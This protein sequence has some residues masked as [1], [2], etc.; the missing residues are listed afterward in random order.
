MST[1]I[2]VYSVYYIV[3]EYNK[4]EGG[5]WV[6]SV[7]SCAGDRHRFTTEDVDTREVWSDD[8]W[9]GYCNRVH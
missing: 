7:L 9:K 2:N 3:V 6:Y 1:V 8:E 4:L 5:G